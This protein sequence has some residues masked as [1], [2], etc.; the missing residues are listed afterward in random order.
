MAV[1]DGAPVIRPVIRDARPDD[2]D[3]LIA[4]FHAAVRQVAVRDYTPQQIAAWAP[5]PPDRQ[6]W[7]TRRENGWRWVGVAEIDGAA[8][9]FCAMA[10]DGLLDMMFTHPA[11]LRRGVASSLL[12]AAEAFAERDGADRL[13]THASITARPFFASRGFTG[14]T[15]QTVVRRGASFVNYRMTKTLARP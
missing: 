15:A 13:T 10:A 9:G 8:A 7:A 11:F 4:L 1:S 5:D 2:L 3:T 14:A 12:S 6:A